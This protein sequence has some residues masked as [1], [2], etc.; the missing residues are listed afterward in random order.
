MSAER[1]SNGARDLVS[2]HR[3]P[4]P[5]FDH[6]IDRLD[7]PPNFG[8][9]ENGLVRQKLAGDSTSCLVQCGP[10]LVAGGVRIK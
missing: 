1:G 9:I 2:L 4:A 5:E 6:R 8:V 3:H 7:F 10:E